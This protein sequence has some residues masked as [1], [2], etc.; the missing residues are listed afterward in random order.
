M[1]VASYPGDGI[2]VEQLLMSADG[3]L[4]QAKQNG[5]NQIR[6]AGAAPVRGMHG[7]SEMPSGKSREDQGNAVEDRARQMP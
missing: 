7:M 3:A 4:L 2:S 5:R 1:G 6:V